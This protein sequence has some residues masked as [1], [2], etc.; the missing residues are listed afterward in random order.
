[1]YGFAVVERTKNGSLKR[2]FRKYI[3]N[4]IF[5]L[6]KTQTP[7]YC[8]IPEQPAGRNTFVSFERTF[9]LINPARRAILHVFADT[10]YRLWINGRILSHGPARFLPQKPEYDSHELTSHLIT[11]INH[12]RVEVW[13][14]QSPNFQ[15]VIAPAVF[16]ADGEIE[17][18]GLS[19]SLATP[20][21]WKGRI[22]KDR[23]RD[24]I[25]WSFA[26]GP[27]E[28]ADRSVDRNEFP[29][30]TLTELQLVKTLHGKPQ[31]RS[32]P[33]THRTKHQPVQL[34]HNGPGANDR[35][36]RLGVFRFFLSEFRSYERSRKMACAAAWIYSPRHQDVRLGLFWDAHFLNG[37]PLTAVSD[38]T[39]GNRQNAVANFRKG[40]NLLV[41]RFLIRLET[42]GIPY[43]WPQE[44]ELIWK[45]APTDEARG[46][47]LISDALEENVI[48][49]KTLAELSALPAE[50][51]FKLS[52]DT[53]FSW[54][55]LACDTMDLAPSYQVAWDRAAAVFRPRPWHPEEV[56]VATC[57]ESGVAI[58]TWKFPTEFFG[59]PFFRISGEHPA[60]VDV[61]CE[62]YL[63]AD[64]TAD[65]FRG[66]FLVNS[67]DRFILKAGEHSVETFHT[68]GGRY[69]QLNIRSAP[70]AAFKIE[71]VAVHEYKTPTQP[72]GSFRC[73][74]DFW[75]WCWQ[76]SVRTL[77]SSLDDVWADSPWREQGCY[78]G[79]SLVQFHAHCCLS[80]DMRLPRRI[81]RLWA[82]GQR[83]DGQLPCVVPAHMTR[84]HPDFTL[85]YVR[86]VRD[87]WAHTGDV[88]LVEELWPTIERILKSPTWRCHS[89]GLIST[90][91]GPLFIDW[92][93][94][95]S[96]REGRSA[97]L[98]LL[99]YQ[100][101]QN[102]AELQRAIGRAGSEWTARAM[103]LH[104]SITHQLWSDK[105]CSFVPTIL[106]D[107]ERVAGECLHANALGFSLGIIP[108][109]HTERFL[110]K[111]LSALSNNAKKII[112]HR[113]SQPTHP[114]SPSGQIEP[115]FLFYLLEAL[116]ESG[117]DRAADNIVRDTW[118]V[119]KD[120]GSDTMWE[121]IVQSYFK[122]GSLCHSWSTAPLVYASRQILG[123]TQPVPGAPDI[124]KICPKPHGLHSAT[125][126]L[127]HRR[128]DLRISW[129]VKGGALV[130]R[131]SVP[132]GVQVVCDPP[133]GWERENYC[134][135]IE[136]NSACVTV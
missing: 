41:S 49:D 20:G 44:S 92:S 132:E 111:L 47:F 90:D 131:L 126:V 78:L 86:F 43:A 91:G 50:H 76:T 112:S 4:Y 123:V 113:E 109:Q 80:A 40:W 10:R 55:A 9:E 18:D 3:E 24:T 53:R 103:E 116:C 46:I 124:V 37:R 96:S 14:A 108:L 130:V 70:G 23:L 8:W 110:Q 118:G 106:D 79:D 54:T 51:H 58:I 30:T 48:D 15:S 71:D 59:H 60:K 133:P 104:R 7:E 98:N 65:I 57:G 34:T 28:V 68:R 52:Q 105:D 97:V 102:A 22:I 73:D 115:Y 16:W 11:G 45:S 82:Q 67:T 122:E 66:S 89:D 39:L 75:N 42:W 128:G 84:A 88:E 5:S 121:S 1:M 32:I 125:G 119:M 56:A 2:S 83:E 31:P 64:G 95:K 27:V 74:D 26:I 35:E 114:R 72:T 85:L 100:A 77:N 12:I 87:F 36:Q 21:Q 19:I 62:E 61:T 69:L 101:C 81:L 99:F 6:L 29:E 129:Q 94:R 136:A 127:P 63:R 93:V 107:G 33:P 134:V 25:P 13:S 17:S 135:E 120:C 38:E 117:R